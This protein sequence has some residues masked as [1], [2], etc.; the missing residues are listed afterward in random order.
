MAR[1]APTQTVGRITKWLILLGFVELARG[2][3][4][5][6]A[7]STRTDWQTMINLPYRLKMSAAIRNEWRVRNI[8]DVVP[9]LDGAQWDNTSFNTDYDT[10]CAIERDCLFMV[11][12]AAIDLSAGERAAYRALLKQCE[13]LLDVAHG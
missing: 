11:D 7:S 10:L 8:A 9:S 12:P 3:H 13:A 4:T 2:M 1:A 5:L 6:S